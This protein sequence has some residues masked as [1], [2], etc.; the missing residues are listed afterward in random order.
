MVN[1]KDF[2][3]KCRDY[4]NELFSMKS[5]SEKANLISIGTFTPSAGLAEINISKLDLFKVSITCLLN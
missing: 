4:I 3:F 1:Y 5:L 2:S